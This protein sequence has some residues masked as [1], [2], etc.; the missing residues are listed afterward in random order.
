MSSNSPQNIMNTA[1]IIKL[2]HE[3]HDYIQRANEK[4]NQCNS[5]VSLASSVLFIELICAELLTL[6]AVLFTRN[7]DTET[8]LVCIAFMIPLSVIFGTI[9]EQPFFFWPQIA[10]NFLAVIAVDLL[11]PVWI[12][13]LYESNNMDWPKVDTEFLASVALFGTAWVIVHVMAAVTLMAYNTIEKKRKFTAR[14]RDGA[15]DYSLNSVLDN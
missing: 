4:R 1:E 6:W 13:S 10:C 8:K 11:G 2:R 15:I 14:E 5:T 9:F 3:I 7:D 12:S